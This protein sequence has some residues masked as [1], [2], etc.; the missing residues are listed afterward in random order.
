MS[1][2]SE[3]QKKIVYYDTGK[4]HADLKIRWAF[5]SLG[6][7]E[8]FRLIASGYLERDHRIIDFIE[9]YKEE[10]KLQS[11]KKLSKT[12]QLYKKAEEVKGQFALSEEDIEDIFDVLEKEHPEL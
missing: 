1:E 5:D 4:T 8:F 3:Q 11:K 7:S 6:Q 2:E 10:K 12:R 9:E